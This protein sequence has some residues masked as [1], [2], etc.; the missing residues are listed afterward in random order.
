MGSAPSRVRG[1]HG[2]DGGVTGY[3]DG[4]KR[5]P[6]KRLTRSWERELGRDAEPPAALEPRSSL[7]R[8]RNAAAP[9]ESGGCASKIECDSECRSADARRAAPRGVQRGRAFVGEPDGTRGDQP[10]GT[11]GDQP[12]GFAGPP[13]DRA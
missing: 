8:G 11:R 7:S 6:L 3:L 2:L 4:Q 10:D 5:R 9:T 1:G 12:D 13:F